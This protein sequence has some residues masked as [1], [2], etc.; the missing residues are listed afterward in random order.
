M[1]IYIV[2]SYLYCSC[3]PSTFL[4]LIYAIIEFHF[5]AYLLFL[6]DFMTLPFTA[7]IFVNKL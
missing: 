4:N 1:D 2:Y 5:D 6:Y 7:P 3:V